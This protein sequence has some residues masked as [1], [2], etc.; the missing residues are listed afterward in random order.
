MKITTLK[1]KALLLA[2]LLFTVVACEEEGDKAIMP[3]PETFVAPAFT[4]VTTRPSVELLP[5]NAQ[6]TFETFTWERTQYGVKISTNYEL[7]VSLDETFET[8]QVLATTSNA[9]VDVTVEEMND[10]LLAL[11]VPGFEEGSVFIRLKSTII[12][13]E[14]DP[15]YSTPISRSATTYQV[16]E[17]GNYCSIGIIG[18][19]TAGGW[20]NDTDMVLA[21][22]ERIDKY[23]WTAT[24]YLNTGEV[25]FRAMDGWDVNW[26]AAAFPSGTGTQNGANIPIAAAGYYKVNFNDQTGAYSFTSLNTPVYPTVGIIGSATPGGWDSDTDMTKDPNDPHVWTGTFTLTAGEAKFRANNAWDV[27]WGGNTAPS[28]VGTGGG[29][30]IPVAVGGTYFV[31]FNDATGAYSLMSTQNSTAYPTV[32]II[33][34]A[35]TGGWDSDTD[36]IKN[37]SNPFLW[38]KVITLSE[39]E[40]KFRANNAWDVNWGSGDF[41][42]GVATQNGNNIPT[43][44]GTYFVTFNSGTGEYYFLK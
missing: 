22:P 24:V 4:S 6:A 25:K 31:R 43:K 19:A 8:S 38:S 20:D 28:G 42:G 26:G 16:S 35:Q 7:Q 30:N 15:L 39:G 11:G 23:N 33:G 37:P 10:A 21:D 44:D 17:C 1:Y 2:S 13:L 40:A 29:P 41:P 34:T 12:G 36:M 9:Q 18:S 32:G 27:N 5:E 3:D 14:L